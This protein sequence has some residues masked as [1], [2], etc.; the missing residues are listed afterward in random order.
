[1]K[2][3]PIL[4]SGAFCALLSCS[5][6]STFTTTDTN[7]DGRISTAEVKALL[8]ETTF[9]ADDANANGRVTLAEWQAANPSDSV[10][11]F[12]AR[13]LNRDGSV[14]LEEFRT[15]VQRNGTFDRFI[16]ELDPDRSGFVEATDVDAFMQKHGLNR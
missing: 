4:A 14:T 7:A 11:K 5:T 1:M 6:P 9:K 15:F 13:D 10:A 8:I 16:A 3:L 12:R 2:H